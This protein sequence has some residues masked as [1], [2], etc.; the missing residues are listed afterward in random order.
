MGDGSEGVLE[1]VPGLDIAVD[2]RRGDVERRAARSNVEVGADLGDRLQFDA[3][4]QRRSERVAA[5]AAVAEVE[6]RVA[7]R[8]GIDQQHPPTGR[9]GQPRE[10]RGG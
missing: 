9:G 1:A 3:V 7:L 5:V 10:V 2:V 8:I 4:E 6:H